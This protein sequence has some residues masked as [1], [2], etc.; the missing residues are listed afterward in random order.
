MDIIRG[1]RVGAFVV[2]MDE[3]GLRH[4]VKLGSVLS[5]SD[6]DDHQDT[7]VMQIP[8]GRVVLIQAPLEKVLKWL[9]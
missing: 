5:L 9:S 7:T 2:F 3:N 1:E 8:G 4:A 6:G